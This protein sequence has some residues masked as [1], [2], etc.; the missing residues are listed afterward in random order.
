M[1]LSVDKKVE[2]KP[3]LKL[4]LQKKIEKPFKKNCQEV[5]G[6]YPE[7]LWFLQ[8]HYCKILNCSLPDKTFVLPRVNSIY[9]FIK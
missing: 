7:V 4:K 1:K 3:L 2:Q 6:A 5:G 8:I 9:N